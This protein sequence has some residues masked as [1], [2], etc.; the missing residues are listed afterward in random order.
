MATG[1]SAGRLI[2]LL[3][4]W[5]ILGWGVAWA[6]P[7]PV[8]IDTDTSCAR[9]ISDD[10]DD[11]W[12]LAFAFVSPELTIRGISTVFGN[13]DGQTAYDT[14]LKVVPRLAGKAV[15]AIHQGANQ[16]LADVTAAP[17]AI[18]ALANALLKERLTIV[19]L[20]PLTNL[21]ILLKD[22]PKLAKRIKR[23]VAVA[24]RPPHSGFAYRPGQSLIMHFHD[25]N[26]RK[27]VKAFE[28][29]LKAGVPMTLLPFEAASQATILPEHLSALRSAGGNGAWL[30]EMSEGWMA[31]W[32]ESLREEGFHPFGALA[33][34]ALVAP[35]HF[36][37]T[38]SRAHIN[39]GRSRF[40]TSRE[41]LAVSDDFTDGFSVRY[42]R[43][44][45]TSFRS[46][47]IQ[48]LSER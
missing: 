16:A 40:V 31:F 21:A 30:A 45:R 28:Q 2:L 18:D 14:A 12:A 43:T 4:T 3:T 46:L 44:V 13:V 23:V 37:C 25:L 27:D 17:E 5:L 7:I 11:C 33:V 1:Q 29:V 47:L 15:P 19:A 9:G 42:C 48:R 38:P 34:G 39:R 20:G 35:R 26:F 10:V 6:A 22:R 36:N 24:G 32:D 41:R 8:W